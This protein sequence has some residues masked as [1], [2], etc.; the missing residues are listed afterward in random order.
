MVSL[1]RLSFYSSFISQ[2]NIKQ[3]IEDE[4]KDVD[5]DNFES[6]NK[7][8]ENII[9]LFKTSKYSDEQ[10]EIIKSFYQKLC[11]KYNT[12]DLSVA[13]RSSAVAEDMPNA[14]FAGQ[15]DTF[16]NIQGIDNLLDKIK[17][18]FAS[19]FISRAISRRTHNIGIDQLLMSVGI[20][21]MVRSDIGSSGV[22]FSLD[23]ESGYD[24]AIVINSVFGLGELLVSGKVR[25]DE[26][27][28]DKRALSDKEK[29]PIIKIQ[30]GNKNTKIVYGND[31]IIEI[32][33]NQ[34]EK[35]SLSLKNS[36]V[37]KLGGTI[38]KLEEEYKKIF[39][40]NIGIDIE[41][42]LDGTDKELYIIQTRPETVHSNLNKNE[43]SKY[44]LSEKGEILLEGVP[45]GDKI[46][47]GKIVKMKD[48]NEHEKFTPGDI[49][50]TDMTTPDWEPLMKKSSG[51]ITNK[52]GRTCHA[53]I[54]ARELGINAIVGTSIGYKILNDK[55]EVT[56]S[57]I[58]G[59]GIV[60]SGILKYE[61][62]NFKVNTDVKLPT[63]LMLNLGNPE[64]AFNSSLL[65]SEGVGLTRLE[66]IINNYISIHPSALLNFDKL[67]NTLKEKIKSLIGVTN[68]ET[69]FV[70]KLARGVSQIASA[71]YPKDVIIR[72]SDFK[73][74]EYRNLIGGEL[75]EPMKKIL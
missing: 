59:N 17:E 18:C 49:I 38:L 16:L 55:Q 7:T 28:L 62:K 68:P 30:N 51:I 22:A 54:V 48:L 47:T 13:V 34:F 12:K 26:F 14:S 11:Q 56:I 58:D 72:L 50:L 39:N 27:I 21:K 45:V 65:P 37:V 20:Q 43:I 67:D 40:S 57:T 4:I 10:V 23:P 5:V 70:K 73:S 9:N 64:S 52:G 31:D 29:D 60:Y 8:S 32:E 61:I 36:D 66:F 35:E 44:F 41:W 71:F 63:K 24:K 25:P 2:N 19:L 42:A 69:Y 3:Q 1:Y 74:N 53:A 15:Q 46:S 75:F 6:L 33:T